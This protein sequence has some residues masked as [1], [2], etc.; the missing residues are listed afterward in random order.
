MIA[1]FLS[2]D[3]GPYAGIVALVG[4]VGVL[5]ASGG[6]STQGVEGL[7]DAVRRGRSR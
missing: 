6:A 4:V 2:K 3:A 7:P 5:Y 1:F